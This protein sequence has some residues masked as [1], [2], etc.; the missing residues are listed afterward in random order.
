MYHY[1]VEFNFLH[2]VAVLVYCFI[3]VHPTVSGFRDLSK[4]L[5]IFLVILS[6][7]FFLMYGPGHTWSTFSLIAKSLIIIFMI[8]LPFVLSMTIIALG[9][10]VNSSK[11]TVGVLAFVVGTL[12]TA[13]IFLGMSLSN[14][15]GLLLVC[16]VTGDCL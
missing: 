13:P 12:M 15:V 5:A 6:A 11:S 3:S 1:Y 10:R 9:N 8:S 16:H 14:L 7:I 2:L 4:S